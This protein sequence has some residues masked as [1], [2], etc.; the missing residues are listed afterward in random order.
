MQIVFYACVGNEDMVEFGG[1]VMDARGMWEVESWAS[2]VAG[3]TSAG[4]GTVL[5]EGITS[6]MLA[7][8]RESSLSFGAQRSF[9]LV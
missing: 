4:G 5:A 1:V 6:E 7:V 8:A 3:R 2:L 9:F